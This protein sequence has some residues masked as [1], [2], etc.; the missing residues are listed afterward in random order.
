MIEEETILTSEMTE[1]IK[2]K[3]AKYKNPSDADQ[4]LQELRNIETLGGVKDL[5]DRIY[6]EWFVT[7]MPSFCTDYPHLQK[8][9]KNVCNKIGI[10]QAQVMIVEDTEDGDEYTLIKHFAE[11]F[12][13]AG[14][15]VRRKMEYIPCE[16]C[17]CAIPTEQMY[18]YLKEKNF[19]VP[20]T[21]DKLCQ[22]CIE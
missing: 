9:W 16:K 18:H 22:K 12:T 10:P 17:A 4:I 13:R 7:V 11:C 19:V 21:W 15:A 20:E 6:P 1:Y 14:F 8:N 5:V 2:E 3:T